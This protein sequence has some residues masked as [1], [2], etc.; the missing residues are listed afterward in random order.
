MNIG[1]KKRQSILPQQVQFA[2][3]GLL[4]II[5]KDGSQGLPVP[6][7]NQ[8]L[9]IGSGE[10]CEIRIQLLKVENVHAKLYFDSNQKAFIENYSTMFGIYLNNNIFTGYG[11][12]CEL[13]SGDKITIGG[14]SFEFQFPIVADESKFVSTPGKASPSVKKTPTP[15]KRND[16]AQLPAY[17]SPSQLIKATAESIKTD[18]ELD[19]SYMSEVPSNEAKVVAQDDIS[20]VSGDILPADIVAQPQTPV[21]VTDSLIPP[22]LSVT[23]E[24]LK[25]GNADRSFTPVPA[26][27]NA[28]NTEEL[29]FS[30]KKTPKSSA[31]KQGSAKKQPG[32]AQKTP[33]DKPRGS[34]PKVSSS[35]KKRQLADE[36]MVALESPKKFEETTEIVM[37]STVVVTEEVEKTEIIVDKIQQLKDEFEDLP[38]SK[39]GTPPGPVRVK[40]ST[41]KTTHP[42]KKRSVPESPS[43]RRQLKFTTEEEKKEESAQVTPKKQIIDKVEMPVSS[44]KKVKFGPALSP[45]IIDSQNPSSQPLKKGSPAAARSPKRASGSGLFSILKSPSRARSGLSKEI[46]P[47]EESPDAIVAKNTKAKKAKASRKSST[48]LVGLKELV[49]TPVPEKEVNLVGVRE[50]VKT[51]AVAKELN[52]TGMRELVKTPKEQKEMELLGVKEL[53]KTPAPAKEMSLVGVKELVKTP[54]AQEEPI[55]DGI[56]QAFKSP[57]PQKETESSNYVGVKEALK[58]P[59]E[60]QEMEGVEDIAAMMKTPY[61]PEVNAALPHTPSKKTRGKSLT[62]VKCKDDVPESAVADAFFSEGRQIRKAKSKGADKICPVEP[63]T[64]SIVPEQ[65][66]VEDTVVSRDIEPETPSIVPEQKS[67]EDTVVSRD[68]ITENEASTMKYPEATISM[69]EEDGVKKRGGPRKSTASVIEVPVEEPKNND[70]NENPADNEKEEVEDAPKKRGRP[71]KS[72]TAVEAPADE[73]SIKEAEVEEQVEMPTAVKVTEQE[74]QEQEII[75]KSEVQEEAPKKRGRAKKIVEE[76]ATEPVSEAKETDEAPKKRGRPKKNA[77][78]P[79]PE[80]KSSITDAET[81]KNEEAPKRRGRAKKTDSEENLADFKS[82]VTEAEDSQPATEPKSRGRPK[83]SAAT[84]VVED[85]KSTVSEVHEAEEPKRRGR[86]KK[87]AAEDEEKPEPAVEQTASKRAKSKKIVPELETAKKR[88]GKSTKEDKEEEVQNAATTTVEPDTTK[89]RG[90]PKKAKE[91]EQE[92]MTPSIP[93]ET[94][95]TK[96][97]VKSKRAATAAAVTET[98]ENDKAGKNR[99]EKTKK[100]KQPEQ[101]EAEEVVE[102]KPLRSRRK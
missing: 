69:P 12:V 84:V 47:E 39:R 60:T 7:Q 31:K 54:K 66:S 29:L 6:I 85:P 87:K 79:A 83:K 45:E 70:V 51:P 96:K 19:I 62:A 58:T 68:S 67:V 40:L 59:K 15:V 86:A 98:D 92:T 90:R 43:F 9:L 11:Q 34:L 89:K 33:Q 24:I 41:P 77:G 5:R 99:S 35:V 50:L 48:D 63:E 36:I 64:P 23:K 75:I 61:V 53:V 18:A 81:A 57:E 30:P 38:E 73:Q 101:V 100:R 88:R 102:S 80:P 42:Y 28:P 22:K 26:E 55:L 97:S 13:K 95:A 91:P 1:P 27:S 14:R 78:T 17:S 65:K 74:A 16:S 21:V 76:V 46:L 3:K 71:K 8:E 94:V 32:S 10:Q 93:K 82:T 56:S 20:A 72:V 52:L 44:S 2:Y 37:E 4:Y 25:E 49:K